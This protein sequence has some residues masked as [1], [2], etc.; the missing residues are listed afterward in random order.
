MSNEGSTLKD[1]ISELIGNIQAC[2]T[3]DGVTELEKLYAGKKKDLGDAITPMMDIMVRDAIGGRKKE[4]EDAIEAEKEAVADRKAAEREAK[5]ASKMDECEHL[6]FLDFKRQGIAINEDLCNVAVIAHVS[7]NPPVGSDKQFFEAIDTLSEKTGGLTQVYSSDVQSQY[8]PL[9]FEQKTK[10]LKEYS[11]IEILRS[12]GSIHA[13]L[14]G[15]LERDITEVYALAST[16]QTSEFDRAG[17]Y[18]LQQGGQKFTVV[19]YQPIV[20]ENVIPRV[21]VSALVESG[22]FGGFVD[23]IAMDTQVAQSMY[24][25]IEDALDEFKPFSG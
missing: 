14:L 12:P 8:A 10:Y 16:S 6:S 1:R 5:A 19:E 22:D 18:F 9:T 17:R 15:L 11:D 3:I 21:R 2:S 20:A 23:A 24:E 25:N 7:M 13:V 4:I